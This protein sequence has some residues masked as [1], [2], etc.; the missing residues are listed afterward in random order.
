MYGGFPLADGS[1]AVV[2]HEP[3]RTVVRRL[4]QGA[5][6]LL[7]DLGPGAINVSVA[8]NGREIAYELSGRGIFVLDRPGASPR[9]LGQGTRPCFAPD[10]SSLLVNRGIET[11][12]LALD[13]SVT[14]VTGQKAGFA[15]AAGCLS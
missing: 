9:S 2:A 11:V 14:V 12:A 8:P 7:A 1:V 15:G 3:G 10:G 5:S 13:G 4:V 6:Q